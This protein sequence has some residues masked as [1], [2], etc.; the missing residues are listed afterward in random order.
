MRNAARSTERSCP[1]SLAPTA[2]DSTIVVPPLT[3]RMTLMSTFSSVAATVTA[4]SAGAPSRAIQT[5]VM[6]LA[7]TPDMSSM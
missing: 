5:T 6:M 7:M 4:A 3:A 1:Y 2:R